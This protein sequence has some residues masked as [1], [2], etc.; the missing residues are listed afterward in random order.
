SSKTGRSL[1]TARP[2]APH[3]KSA[4]M[5]PRQPLWAPRT[6]PR[7]TG[8][9]SRNGAEFRPCR[10]RDPLTGGGELQMMAIMG[11]A[12]SVGL[13]G[14]PPRCGWASGFGR[15]GFAS[16][17]ERRFLGFG[18]ALPLDDHDHHAQRHG[19]DRAPDV[20]AQAEDDEARVEADG[21]PDDAAGAVPH[22]VDGEQAS[23]LEEDVA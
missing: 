6:F 4:T 22:E 11:C 15:L 18:V 20:R 13:R 5:L 17:D 10:I 16:G 9:R 19:A 14:G 2:R 8:D 3:R 7:E 12:A 21:L 23:P 1:M